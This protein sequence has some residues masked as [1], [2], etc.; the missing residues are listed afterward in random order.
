MFFN[1]THITFTEN[2]LNAYK[3]RLLVL[4]PELTARDLTE[5][6]DEY[7]G[8]RTFLFSKANDRFFFIVVNL[9]TG[10]I[11]RICV[12]SCKRDR[13]L[14]YE[15]TKRFLIDH[16]T[17]KA[18]KKLNISISPDH[19]ETIEQGVLDAVRKAMRQTAE[20]TFTPHYEHVEDS[21]FD[22]NMTLH[23]DTRLFTRGIYNFGC[24]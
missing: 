20:P 9:M 8:Y 11:P 19:Q 14:N 3:F 24:E 1:L 23:A 16:I 5:D 4:C 12:L 10:D 6:N 7:E 13:L 15:E 2:T 17:G 18:G 22:F 21:S